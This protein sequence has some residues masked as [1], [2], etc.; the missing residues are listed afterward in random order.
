MGGE[1]RSVDKD[2]YDPKHG[3]KMGIPK[4]GCDDGKVRDFTLYATK[5]NQTW[6]MVMY[7]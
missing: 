3:V 6:H 4:G 7:F 2:M 5:L 1:K